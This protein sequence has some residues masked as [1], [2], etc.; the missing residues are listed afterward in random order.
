MDTT[1]KLT[2]YPMIKLP[3]RKPPESWESRK[4]LIV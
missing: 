1:N 4:G 2:G 3:I